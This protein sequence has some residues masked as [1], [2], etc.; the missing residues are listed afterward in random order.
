M[1]MPSVYLGLGEQLVV[2]VDSLVGVYS[3]VGVGSLVG[4]DTQAASLG[5]LVVEGDTQVAVVGSLV[6]DRGIPEGDM[7]LAVGVGSPAAVGD[8]LVLVEYSLVVETVAEKKKN[9][10]KWIILS[11]WSYF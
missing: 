9:I 5:S 7:Q 4:V 11:F 10:N 8:M 2:G 1:Y 3:L 6:V